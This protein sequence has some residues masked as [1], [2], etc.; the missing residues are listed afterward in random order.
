MVCLPLGRRLI[1]VQPDADCGEFDHGGEFLVARCDA[2]D[3]FAFVVAGADCATVV[4]RTVERGFIAIAA[5][6]ILNA[7]R[8]GRPRYRSM[9]QKHRTPAAGKMV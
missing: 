6:D 8:A 5:T 7:C 4:A 3:L 9:E 2:S 1:G